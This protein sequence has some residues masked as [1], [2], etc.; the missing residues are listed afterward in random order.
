MFLKKMGIA[1]IY[2]T[3]RTNCTGKLENDNILQVQFRYESVK[4]WLALIN[5]SKY[6]DKNDVVVLFFFFSN[7]PNLLSVIPLVHCRR[8]VSLARM[9]LVGYETLAQTELS[10]F[11]VT[12]AQNAYK[13]LL[14]TNRCSINANI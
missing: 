7:S 13:S 1:Q 10:G 9:T 6:F 4:L 2:T 12:S 11:R 14:Y 8:Q 5:I 3:K